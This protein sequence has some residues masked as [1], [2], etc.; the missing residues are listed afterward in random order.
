MTWSDIPGWSDDI[1]GPT[2]F[3]EFIQE[4][5]PQAGVIVEVGV[6]MGRSLA[7]IGERRP[8]VKLVAVDLWNP[9]LGKGENWD[10]LG[11][12]INYAAKRDELGPRGLFEWLMKTHSPDVFDRLVQVQGEYR[13]GDWHPPADLIFIDARH[14]ESVYLDIEHAARL[15]KPS[16]II[17]G[18]D[19]TA[20]WSDGRK[21]EWPKNPAYPGVVSA[22]D[23][24]AKEHNRTVRLDGNPLGSWSS[25]WWLQ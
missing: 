17:A 6:F 12:P 16:G 20:F 19:Y 8:D 3:Y 21:V 2:G 14:D 23:R 10:T 9:S 22:V 15:L 5:V 11:A 25:C 13:A 4:R 18:H 7:Y 24:W 1:A